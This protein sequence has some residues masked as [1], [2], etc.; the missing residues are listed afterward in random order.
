MTRQDY[1]MCCGH[2]CFYDFNTY[3]QY[4]KITKSYFW[5]IAQ[6]DK[7]LTQF[8]NPALYSD[9]RLAFCSLVLTEEQQRN[10]HTT[11][12]KHGFNLAE[13]GINYLHGS[14]L[15]FYIRPRDV[16]FSEQEKNKI[17]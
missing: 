5:D 8:L 15:Y 10:L 12:I 14:T 2:K 3:L 6:F 13:I 4:D 1:I 11:I 16:A 17:L 9:S 7:D